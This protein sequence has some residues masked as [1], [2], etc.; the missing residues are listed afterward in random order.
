MFLSTYK[1]LHGSSRVTNHSSGLNSDRVVV[2]HVLDFIAV[3]GN[4]DYFV[5]WHLWV[6]V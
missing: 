1:H 4:R 5:C 6:S 3:N 2:D